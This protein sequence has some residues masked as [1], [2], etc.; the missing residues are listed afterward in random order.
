MTC[1]VM[2]ADVSGR[3]AGAVRTPSFHTAAAREV[4]VAFV[5][6]SGPAGRHRQTATISGAGLK[7]TLVKRQNAPPGDTEVWTATADQV[8]V[9]ASV[10]STLSIPGY[11]QVLTVIAMEG[12]SGIGASVAAAGRSADPSV[13]L[14]TKGGTSLVFAVGNDRAPG[15]KAATLGSLPRGWVPLEQWLDSPN[16]TSNW[17]QYTNDPTGPAGTVVTVARGGLAPG[18]WNLVAVELRNDDA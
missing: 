4:L 5:S 9:D 7:W 1:F 12:V 13:H 11:E 6:A 15:P 3:A 16:K 10:R 17:S 14:T 2:Q 18:P 8:P